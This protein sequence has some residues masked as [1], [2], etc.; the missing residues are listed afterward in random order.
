MLPAV[1]ENRPVSVRSAEQARQ[2]VAA[3]RLEE[4]LGTGECAW[5]DA[6]RL[7]YKAGR[8]ADDMELAK[9][10]AAFANGSGGLLLIG[11]T[12]VRQHGREILDAL[13]PL[14][15]GSVDVERYR[16]LLRGRLCPLVRGLAV[17]W[18]PVD[19]RGGAVVVDVPEQAEASK[20]F[21]VS[22]RGDTEGFSVPVRDGDGTH[23]LAREHVQQLLSL[24]WNAGGGSGRQEL[25]QLLRE[26][27]DAPAPEPPILPGQGEPSVRTAFER[28]WV[29]GGGQDTLGAPIGPVQ[30]IGPGLIQQLS[31]GVLC[32][33]DTH[34][35][36]AVAISEPVWD[37]VL[38]IGA[39]AQQHGAVALGLPNLRAAGREQSTDATVIDEHAG[40]IP[41]TGGSWGPGW[42][43]RAP[44]GE[45]SWQPDPHIDTLMLSNLPAVSGPVDLRLRAVA[46]LSFA[47]DELSA[48]PRID[49][50]GR[51]RMQTAPGMGQLD[52]LLR[53]LCL[54][55]GGR[56]AP[57]PWRWATGD[58]GYQS[59]RSGQYRCVLETA[60]GEPAL[61][62]EVM[63]QLPEGVRT[64]AMTACV[65]LRVNLAPWC[66]LLAD[67]DPAPADGRDLRFTVGDLGEF[68]LA[69]WPIAALDLPR[70]A[71]PVDAST[72]ALAG[73]ARVEF[74]VEVDPSGGAQHQ[75]AHEVLDLTAFGEP[76]RRVWGQGG[77]G[78]TAP[79]ELPR[80]QRRSLLARGLTDLAHAWGFIDARLDRL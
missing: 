30:R 15:A 77:F 58:E 9:D 59:D 23:W 48:P 16:K 27:R 5:L 4:L 8:P 57:P 22:G 37:A 25:L 20:P 69:A 2:A 7:P 46:T 41:L 63:L 29:A 61:A 53:V 26:A 12:T 76:T 67:G 31:H 44:E 38:R 24:G 68:F 64:G 72:A 70:M 28:A 6:K 73:P 79:L 40:Q 32:T 71:L 50:D 47:L 43:L 74:R 80:E 3:G 18:V 11:F 14:A 51:A 54:R 52:N 33:L 19:D 66:D 55:R 36:A 65:E 56:V 35:S 13:V 1:R 10:V 75:H 78:I 17:D 45:W 21:V 39:R 42:L 34:R 60:G 62:A 49:R